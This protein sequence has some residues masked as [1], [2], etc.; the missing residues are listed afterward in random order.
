M[1]QN[2]SQLYDLIHGHIILPSELIQN[3]K[4]PNYEYVNFQSGIDGLC[5]ETC[6]VVEDV[7][8]VKF[9]YHFDKEDR[10]QKL[11][12]YDGT[13]VEVVFDRNVEIEKL[14]TNLLG[15]VTVQI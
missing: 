3:A 7:R 8:K 4:L 1:K 6:C 9:T 11:L 12:S 15:R 10:L 2:L 13:N 14:R 5:V